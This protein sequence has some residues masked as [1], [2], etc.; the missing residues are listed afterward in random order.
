MKRLQKW[1]WPR[2][3]DLV[4]LGGVAVISVVIV[5]MAAADSG[6]EEPWGYIEG[7]VTA[8][9]AVNRATGQV[10]IYDLR[11]LG[12]LQVGS[13]TFVGELPSFAPNCEA[14]GWVAQAAQ[15]E[16]GAV[17]R[18]LE[19]APLLEGR[20]DD[21]APWFG[22]SSMGI[23]WQTRPYGRIGYDIRLA[24]VAGWPYENSSRFFGIVPNGMVAV[25]DDTVALA[26]TNA[27]TVLRQGVATRVEMPFEP[28]DVA[29][30]M[31]YVRTIADY[32][33]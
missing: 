23:V 18:L 16:F 6:A 25:F 8:V 1:L 17:Y 31:G 11:Q 3:Y 27:V 13:G 4:Q 29:L 30:C 19:M 28:T 32:P 24:P 9:M 14:A 26:G 7:D 5:L 15:N 10:A 20:E 22:S 21:A 12:G 33:Y 2:R